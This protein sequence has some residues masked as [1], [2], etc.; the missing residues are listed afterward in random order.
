MAEP[1]TKVTD[2]SVEE[3]INSVANE[4]RRKDGFELLTIFQRVTGLEPKMWGPSMIGFGVYHYKSQRSSQEGD[5]PLV[6]F[7]PRKQS[8]TLY[9]D[10]KSFP[11]LL[12]DLGKHTVSVSCLYIN[13]LDDVDRDVLEELVA[14]SFKRAKEQFA[15]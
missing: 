6:G 8:L 12:K 9:V 13:K 5:W 10:P 1:K 7:S 2:A 11:E 14:T 3:F 15:Q 4:R